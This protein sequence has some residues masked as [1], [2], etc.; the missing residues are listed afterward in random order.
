MIFAINGSSF[1]KVID[2]QN[3]LCIT[4][5]QAKTLPADVCVFG[6]FRRLSPAAVHSTDSQF[7]SGMKWSI[8]VSSIVTHWCKTPFCCYETVANNALNSR[9]VVVFDRLW[10]NDPPTLNTAISLTNIHVKLWIHC[11]L[12]S[13][14]PLLS[15]ETSIY[16]RPKRVC[17][18]FFWGG[19]LGQLSNLD[20]H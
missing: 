18:V 17:G 15:H 20:D 6:R 5:Y 1:L 3:T 12:I 9:R 16:D 7:D 4:K 11:L 2:E 8:H 10:A 14:P 13:S 19:G